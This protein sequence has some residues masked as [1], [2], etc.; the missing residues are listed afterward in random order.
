MNPE[1]K[2][3]FI[4]AGIFILAFFGLAFLLIQLLN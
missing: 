1:T 3:E 2:T 4:K